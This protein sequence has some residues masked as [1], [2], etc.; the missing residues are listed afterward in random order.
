MEDSESC[1]FCLGSASVPQTSASNSGFIPF[2]VEDWL[3]VDA[4]S[5]QWKQGSLFQHGSY[6]TVTALLSPSAVIPVYPKQSVETDSKG[7]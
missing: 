1:I 3:L 5:A 4:V 7:N 6:I 2:T